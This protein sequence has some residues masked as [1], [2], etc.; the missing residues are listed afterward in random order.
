L[1]AKRSYFRDYT[2][3]RGTRSRLTEGCSPRVSPVTI[4]NEKKEEGNSLRTQ[5]ADESRKGGATARA[6]GDAERGRHRPKFKKAERGTLEIG[7]VKVKLRERTTPTQFTT[8]QRGRSKKNA[9][10]HRKAREKK[11]SMTHHTHPTA[12]TVKREVKWQL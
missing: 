1:L 8:V 3:W 10:I 12:E 9:Q 6:H 7:P 11:G 5:G 4:R 2:T